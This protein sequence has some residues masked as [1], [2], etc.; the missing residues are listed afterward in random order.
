MVAARPPGRVAPAPGEAVEAGAPRG[1]RLAQG[2]PL[3]RTLRFSWRPGIAP[4]DVAG[5]LN[6][7]LLYSFTLGVTQ[8]SFALKFC[9]ADVAPRV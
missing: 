4:V 3:L 8:L 7:N 5:I 2:L 1:V 9:R 6:A